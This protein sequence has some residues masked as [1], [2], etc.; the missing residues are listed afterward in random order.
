MRLTTPVLT[1][2]LATAGHVPAQA[3]RQTA[4]KILQDGVNENNSDRRSR[5]V[6]ALGL[7][8]PEGQAVTFTERALEDEK[9]SVR[10]AAATAL[11]EMHARASI[12]K[13]RKALS[14]TDGTV[15]LAAAQS[16]VT[17]KDDE[18]YEAYYEVLTG[19]RKTGQGLVSEGLAMLRDSKKL[20][21][22]GFEEGIG[23]VPFG[24]LG[25]SAF[26]ALT[27][28]DVS[29]VR[30]AAARILAHD[31]DPRSGEALGEAVSDKSGAVR[32]AALEAIA[33]RDD[34]SLLS[35][36]LPA[37]SDSDDAVRY[38]AAS[39]VIRLATAASTHA[40]KNPSKRQG[41]H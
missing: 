32:T 20:A 22:F 31:P 15:V 13:L 7:L 10:R 24:G 25:F 17:L 39:A 33:R 12:P 8:P 11:G 36:I 16:L 4:W 19:Q 23:F 35:D 28:D 41:R 29:P 2:L 40:P 1:L 34:P 9:P 37:L 14:D 18:G 30:A 21:E 6:R 5:A 3:P 27:K 38:T 26:K